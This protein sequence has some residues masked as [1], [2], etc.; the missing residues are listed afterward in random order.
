M[1]LQTLSEIWQKDFARPMIF[2]GNNLPCLRPTSSPAHS[3]ATLQIHC[4]STTNLFTL[5]LFH[6]HHADRSINGVTIASIISKL[7]NR[8]PGTESECEEQ[9]VPD[10]P[11]KNAS[12]RLPIKPY[13]I[14]EVTK[15]IKINKYIN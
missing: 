12:S 11:N 2:N 13:R 7:P 15:N 5:L 14:W 8:I 6:T 1:R 9:L 4:F 3:A 10:K